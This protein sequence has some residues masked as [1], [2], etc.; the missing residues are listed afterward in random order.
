MN[1]F[2]IKIEINDFVSGVFNMNHLLP[3]SCQNALQ[4]PY[5]VGLTQYDTPLPPGWLPGDSIDTQ[6]N[7]LIREKHGPLVG[8]VDLTN[9]TRFGFSSRGV[10]QYLFY[11]LHTGYPPMIV[12]SK[13]PTTT[14]QFGIVRFDNWNTTKSKWPHG[15]LQELLGHVGNSS[16]ELRA[17]RL[18]INP[19][20]RLTIPEYDLSIAQSSQT[21]FP[22]TDN[23][24][25]PEVWDACFNIDPV[26]CKDV[27][28]VISWRWMPNETWEFG[29]HIANVGAWVPHNSSLDQEAM[30]RG[31]T[32]YEEGQVLRPML[33]PVL[34]EKQASLLSDGELR[35]VVSTIWTISKDGIC[36]NA[37]PTWRSSQITIH[38]SYSYEN[39]LQKCDICQKLPFFL[40]CIWGSNIGPD[41]H[42]WI[43]VAM[44]VY[45]RAAA[46]VLKTREAGILRRHKGALPSAQTLKL[47]ADQS[48]CAEIAWLGQAAGEYCSVKT[49]STK[50]CEHVG[51][52]E[53]LYCHASSPLRRYAD[54][55]NQRILVKCLE[56]K[57]SCEFEQL[58][59]QLNKTA[60]LVR[61]WERDI[62]CMKHL[63]TSEISEAS[64]WI[65]GWKQKGEEIRLL[66]YVPLWKRSVRIGFF[67]SHTEKDSD[68]CL[69][70]RNLGQEWIA[71]QGQAVQVHAFCNLRNPQ[72]SE[73][74]VFSCTP[75]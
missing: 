29:I 20:G 32:V 30:R 36:K 44:I 11:P 28:D 39:V 75:I 46:H 40:T 24:G 66:V 48:G 71:K 1:A 3:I 54:L 47:I 12:G 8:I 41:P 18:Y 26:G 74:F 27:D 13:A 59:F 4:G 63:K 69:K 64:G 55:V 43:E 37:Q 38:S 33:P 5:W 62:W 56:D 72:F 17:L 10:S 68:I 53:A 19:P 60:K 50:D 49:T 73:R 9:R 67:Q 34:S 15:A 52:G 58:S 21:L 61:A 57:T 70:P 16:V 25:S 2:L 6:T 22:C 7:K 45:N 35:P 42:R 51:L 31:I 14:N 23:C 65:L